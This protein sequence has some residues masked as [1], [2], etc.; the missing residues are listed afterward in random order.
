MPEHL[1]SMF[2]LYGNTR[3]I[4]M[5]IKTRQSMQ[6]LTHF[7]GTKRQVLK[8]LIFYNSTFW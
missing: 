5:G 3:Q 6:A 2:S 1:N 4:G 7:Y 8:N